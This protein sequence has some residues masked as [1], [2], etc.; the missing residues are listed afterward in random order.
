MPFVYIVAEDKA[1]MRFYVACTEKITGSPLEYEHIVSRK[2]SGIGMARKMARHMLRMARAA[3]D[4][5]DVFW[6]AALDNDRAPQHPDGAQ[7]TAGKLPKKDRSKANRYDELLEEAGDAISFG[8]IA[9]PVEMIESWVLQAL[10]SDETL[11]LPIFAKQ[12]SPSAREFHG[13]NPPP[14]LKDRAKEAM[15]NH[16]A[17]SWP[18]FLLDVAAKL[19]PDALSGHSRS[20][21]LFRDAVAAWEIS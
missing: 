2:G 1:D 20:F 11:K 14:Q 13:G 18:D 10:S 3:A 7:P 17:E 19:D 4:G 16:D 8:A 9:V 6:I 15:R 5:G 12:N 21:R